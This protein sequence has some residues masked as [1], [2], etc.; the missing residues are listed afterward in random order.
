MSRGNTTVILFAVFALGLPLA[1]MQLNGF[2]R[3]SVHACTGECYEDWVAVSGGVVSMAQA[4]AD[5]R[6]AASPRELG[7]L[8]Y[9]G[10]VA[11]HGAAGEG[12]IG[13]QLAGQS[14]D[15]ILTALQQYGNG[16][17][18]GDQ[19]ALMWSQAATLTG[20]DMA[21]LADYIESL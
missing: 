4:Q 18:R 21:N 9:N 12:G 15:A 2:D 1:A 7:K 5:E 19:S 13:P 20:D 16:E 3:D 10:C 11:C 6:A 8:A 17:T 14:A